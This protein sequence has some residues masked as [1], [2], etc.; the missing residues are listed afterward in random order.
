MWSSSG[1][2]VKV[3]DTSK[4]PGI[5]IAAFRAISAGLVLLGACWLTRARKTWHPAMWIMLASFAA[6]NYMFI[7]SMTQTSAANT[8][9]LQYTAPIWMV[10]GSAIWLGERI[11]RKSAIASAAGLLG[12][13]ILVRGEWSYEQNQRMGI[14]LGLGSGVAYAGVAVCLRKLRNH[15][16]LWMAMLNHLVAGIVLLAVLGATNYSTRSDVPLFPSSGGLAYLA[17][18]GIFQ[19]AI[20]YVLFGM[21]LQKVSAQEAGVL[22]LLEPILNPL[23]TYLIAGQAPSG[24]TIAGGSVL[25]AALLYRCIADLLEARKQWRLD[26]SAGDQ[27]KPR[28]PS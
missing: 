27:G 1:A 12:I 6:M 18:F 24:S 25:I 17:I 7:V 9:F 21:G 15:D 13:I 2:F 28:E 10:I 14:L 22:T 26:A 4:F 19:M 20:P 16:S 8:I 5:S 3:L 11:D 23:W